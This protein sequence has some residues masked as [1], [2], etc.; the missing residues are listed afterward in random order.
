MRNVG[1]IGAGQIGSAITRVL[2]ESG[3][4]SMMASRRKVYELEDLKKLGVRVTSDNREVA[5]HSDIIILAVKPYK[6]VKVLEEVADLLEGK[7]VISVA[8]A[9]PIRKLKA[10]APRAKIVRAM[11]NV[12][13]MVKASFTAYAKEPGLS[14]KD[15]AVVVELLKEMGATQEVDE[16]LMDAVTALSGSGPAY[17]ATLIEAMAYA[18]L[19]VG[20]PRDF[21]Y[22]SSAYTVYGTAKLYLESGKHPATIKEMVLT[23]AGTTIEGIFYLEESGIRTAIMKAVEAAT[24]RAREIASKLNSDV[25]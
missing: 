16:E 3:R 1:I 17:I 2:A 22:L 19:K 13:V 23:P 7:I 14:S 20:L 11:P 6:A 4:W 5:S 15:E 9:V 21:A 8:A 10:A 25:V 24:K 12:A 18:G